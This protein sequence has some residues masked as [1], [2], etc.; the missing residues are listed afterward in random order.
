PETGGVSVTMSAEDLAK[1][2]KVRF[3]ISC[4]EQAQTLFSQALAM[5]HS[6]WYDEAS[7]TFT[8]A[9]DA[10]PSCAMGHWGIA[11]SLY[12]PLWTNPTPA[13]LAKGAAAVR[14]AREL[15]PKTARE[16][17]YVEAIATFYAAP[18]SEHRVRA[19]AYEAALERLYRRYRDDSEAAAFYSL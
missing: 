17:D 1:L 5:L 6:F 15:G 7:C 19:K 10:D 11:M 9:L 18:D 3:P 8:A 2:G 14:K 12:H 13:E 4:N 16:R